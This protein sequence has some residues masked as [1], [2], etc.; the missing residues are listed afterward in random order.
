M[1]RSTLGWVWAKAILCYMISKGVKKKRRRWRKVAVARL[2]NSGIGG[3]TGRK[4]G[5]AFFKLGK[6]QKR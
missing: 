2:G 6:P 3:V 4:W 1:E 5:I